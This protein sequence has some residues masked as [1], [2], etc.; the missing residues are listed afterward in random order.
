MRGAGNSSIEVYVIQEYFT[1]FARLEQ[2][3][4]GK[5]SLSMDLPNKGFEVKFII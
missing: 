5:V 1:K 2:S 3:W 4:Y